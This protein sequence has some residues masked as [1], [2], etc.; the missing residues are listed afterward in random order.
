M[1]VFLRFLGGKKLTVHISTK[2]RKEHLIVKTNI[3][4]KITNKKLYIL[5]NPEMFYHILSLFRFYATLRTVIYNFIADM[6][7]CHSESN[8]SRTSV[9]S[10]RVIYQVQINTSQ[11]SVI[12]WTVPPPTDH[13]GLLLGENIP[14]GGG[15]K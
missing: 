9:Y 3:S 15:D 7:Q 10:Y 5:W 8:L 2:R 4:G 6:C 14:E 13:N 1:N 11:I 12:L